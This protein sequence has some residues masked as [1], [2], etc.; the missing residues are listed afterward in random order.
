MTT[1]EI[2]RQADTHNPGGV[3]GSR[4]PGPP[5]VR[6]QSR[7]ALLRVESLPGGRIRVSSPQARGWAVVVR[8][9]DELVRAVAQA[10]T[11]VQVASYARWR[12]EPYELDA[13]TEV[14]DLDPLAASAA[15][16]DMT[17]TAK[18]NV[19]RTDVHK[20]TDWTPVGNGKW[21]SPTGREYGEDTQQVRR[22]KAKRRALGLGIGD[23]T[24]G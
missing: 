15:T 8:T 13:L 22:V 4:L 7:T 3:N 5:S 11:E 1:V 18:R 19:R 20:V 16:V 14:D 9:R 17:G 23:D 12:G 10:F 6:N 24:A 21:R 2:R